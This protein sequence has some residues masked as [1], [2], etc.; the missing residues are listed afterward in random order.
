MRKPL[1]LA[2]ACFLCFIFSLKAQFYYYDDKHL[3][4]GLLFEA[5]LG[6]GIMNC[7]TD[8]GGGKGTGRKF[9]KDINWK[10]S[11]PVFSIYVSGLLENKAGI[12]IEASFGDVTA[13]DSI[14][15]N[16]A[17]STSG[18][19]ERNLSFRSTINEIQLVG[20]L[21]PLLFFHPDQAPRLSPY[22]IAGAGIFSFDPKARLKGIWYSLQPLRTEGQG[23]REYPERQPYKLSQVNVS[24]GLGLRY[25][26]I[27]FLNARLEINYRFLGTDY[28]DDVSTSYLDPNLFNVYLPINQA[29]VA[30]QLYDRT[31]ERIPSDL[32]GT[33]DQRGNPRNNDSYFTVQLMAGI[34][35]GRVRR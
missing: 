7:I 10:N 9:I 26:L 24:A 29:T 1:I 20:E 25:E 31:A 13:Y 18:R 3:E 21:H 22:A 32:P 15:K 8:L 6:F 33:S 27:S 28:L 2:S 11:K 23:F 19:Y 14:L 16:I 12:R 5:G 17:S 34:V 30:R 4:N 35:L